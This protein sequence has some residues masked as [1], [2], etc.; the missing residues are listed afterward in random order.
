MH[1][2]I[3]AL[4]TETFGNPPSDVTRLTADG[5]QRVYFRLSG[6]RQG[7]VIGAVGPD[8][9]ENRAF[10]SFTRSFRLIRLPVPEVYAVNE[11][12]G[13]WLEEDLGDTT[14]FNALSSA[15]SSDMEAFPQEMLEVYERVV[16]IL[17]RFQVE[18]GRAVDF[19]VAYP[20]PEFDL[21]SMLWDL[22]YFKYHFLKLAHIPFNEQRLEND[23]HRLTEHLLEAETR[24]FLY[25]DFQ[26][27]NIMLRGNEP[28]FIDYQGGRRGAPQYDIASLLYDA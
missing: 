21:Q 11:A 16:E 4:F 14:L 23:F 5:S 22:N 19:S 9:D 1:N 27:R 2:A 24:H 28:W 10:L 18:G 26:S 20:R 12:Q 13:V 3:A 15:R 25:R 17:P 8:P 6:A 7:S